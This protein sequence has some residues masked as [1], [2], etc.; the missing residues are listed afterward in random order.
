V[1][2]KAGIANPEWMRSGLEAY[3]SKDYQRAHRKANRNSFCP[4]K[5]EGQLRFV[6]HPKLD[7]APTERTSKIKK[8]KKAPL[9]AED[10]ECA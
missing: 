8:N 7:W 3:C 1:L 5:A 9:T 4:P 6:L 10:S 2:G